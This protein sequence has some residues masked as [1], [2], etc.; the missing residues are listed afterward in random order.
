MNSNII[1]LDLCLGVLTDRHELNIMNLISVWSYT[2]R[3]E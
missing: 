2:D 3:S 1:E